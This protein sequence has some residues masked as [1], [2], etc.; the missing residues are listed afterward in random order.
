MAVPLLL[1]DIRGTGGRDLNHP[2][3]PEDLVEHAAQHPAI[4]LLEPSE[5][6]QYEPLLDGRERH[7]LQGAT[8]LAP[9]PR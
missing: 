7:T 6:A 5:S 1:R 4:F 2:L 9:A 3:G 8:S